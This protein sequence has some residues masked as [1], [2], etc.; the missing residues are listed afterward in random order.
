[1]GNSQNK[2][3]NGRRPVPAS[4]ACRDIHQSN[5]GKTPANVIVTGLPNMAKTQKQREYEQTGYEPLSLR[6]RVAEV[7]P[8]GEGRGQPAIPELRQ[9]GGRVACTH[10]G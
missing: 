10:A 9:E 6:E 5:K 4:P 8:P 7:F 1:M 3:R 2:V